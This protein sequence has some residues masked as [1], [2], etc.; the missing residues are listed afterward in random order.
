MLSLTV[1]SRRFTP[2]LWMTILAF[3]TMALFLRLGFW[4]IA[5]G[6]E[7]KAMIASEQKYAATAPISWMPGER[8]PL[9]YQWIKLK[10]NYLPD[11]LLLDNQHHNHR[12]GYHVLSPLALA[13]G[14]LVLI[15]RGWIPNEG[16]RDKLP[17]VKT[18]VGPQEIIG[19]AYYPSS[20]HI[21][22]GE[23]VEK[24]MNQ[25]SIIEWI[26]IQEI[27]HFLHKSVYPFI[28]RLGEH[29]AHGFIREWP[30]VSMSPERHYA[31]A[32]QWFAMAFV[33]SILFIGLNLKKKT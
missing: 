4:Q 20:K 27:S 16:G 2:S 14:H 10:G 22:L 31:Y 13:N 3:L 18:P 8:Y 33:I 19:Y 21:A 1:F 12:I 11:L 15:D 6:G 17:V 7:K 5:R 25:V 24:K 32:L 26:D 28:I 23:M 29:E 9:K 30:I